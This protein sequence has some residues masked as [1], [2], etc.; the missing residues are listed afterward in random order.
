VNEYQLRDCAKYEESVKRL[1][2]IV[3]KMNTLDMGDIGKWSVQPP[4]M[5]SNR[6]QYIEASHP[7]GRYVIMCERDGYGSRD[8]W[9][10]TAIGWPKYLDKNKQECRTHPSDLWDPKETAPVT[11]AQQ[12]RDP[13]AIARQIVSKILPDYTRQWAR[14]FA[15]AEQFQDRENSERDAIRR[16]AAACREPA[17]WRDSLQKTFYVKEVSGNPIR[18]EY[19]SEGDVKMNLTTDEAIQVVE[20]LRKLREGHSIE[21]AHK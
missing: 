13:L 9:E 16:L 3:E 5:Y 18:L 15:R 20:L 12:D 4:S 19:R 11:T 2:L 10:F 6:V 14:C 17:E 8:R 1:S 21:G 7:L